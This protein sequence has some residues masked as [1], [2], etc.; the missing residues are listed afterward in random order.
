MSA[1]VAGF[2]GILSGVAMFVGVY[3]FVRLRYTSVWQESGVQ[4][5]ARQI[6]MLSPTK[7]GVSERYQERRLY[8]EQWK[9]LPTAEQ[10]RNIWHT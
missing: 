2:H 10:S 3:R 7:D 1:F 4:K 8:Q 6:F 5:A 9:R